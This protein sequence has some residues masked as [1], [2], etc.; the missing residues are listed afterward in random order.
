MTRSLT[1]AV[2]GSVIALA[3]VTTAAKADG[4]VNIYSL[5]QP[6]L[7]E[8]LLEAFTA[9]TGIKTNV[10]FAKEGVVE[11]MKAEGAN[12]P[13]SQASALASPWCAIMPASRAML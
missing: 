12:S 5:R 2:L 3:A 4:E 7:I 13:A 8:P 9:K 11:R 6:F 1:G 10:V